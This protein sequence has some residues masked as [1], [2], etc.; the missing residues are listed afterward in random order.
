M[1]VEYDSNQITVLF[2]A[3]E[4]KNKSHEELFNELSKT[5]NVKYDEISKTIVVPMTDNNFKQV[6]TYRTIYLAQLG[7]EY[8]MLLNKY[9]KKNIKC[10]YAL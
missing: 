5:T 1:K 10:E 7:I 8:E 2:N 6:K 3:D 9:S 4:I